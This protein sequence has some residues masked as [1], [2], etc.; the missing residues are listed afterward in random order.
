MR[1]QTKGRQGT[2]GNRDKEKVTG[3]AKIHNIF[4]IKCLYETHYYL[5]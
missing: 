2:K 1:N 5:Q 4:E 3:D